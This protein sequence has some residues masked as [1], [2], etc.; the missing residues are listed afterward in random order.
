MLNIS[1]T[2]IKKFHTQKKKKKK[3]IPYFQFYHPPSY[4]L[5][6]SGKE[7]HFQEAVERFFQ[8]VEAEVL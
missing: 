3:E 2:V 4:I 7:S 5:I 8:R 6:E 1:N